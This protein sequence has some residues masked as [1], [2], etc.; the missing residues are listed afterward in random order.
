MAFFPSQLIEE[1]TVAFTNCCAHA[2]FGDSNSEA[3][4]EHLLGSVVVVVVMIVVEVVDVVVDEVDVSTVV[5]VEVVMI[6][7]LVVEVVVVVVTSP[8]PQCPSGIQRLVCHP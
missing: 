6:V 5:V 7:E 2:G 1:E 3:L 4:P 8:H